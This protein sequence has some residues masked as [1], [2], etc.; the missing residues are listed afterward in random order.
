MKGASRRRGKKG[1]ADR[2]SAKDPGRQV[3]VERGDE[4][5]QGQQNGKKKGEEKR[6]A[7]LWERGERNVSFRPSK[8]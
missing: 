6:D 8:E 3:N 4:K 7:Y 1:T 2:T 5:F